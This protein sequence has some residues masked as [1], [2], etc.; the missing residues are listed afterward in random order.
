[1]KINDVSL[2]AKNYDLLKKSLDV[3]VERGRVIANNI[4]N[5]NT[6][7]YKRY[8]VT[9]EDSLKESQEELA[10]EVTD[11]KHIKNSVEYGKSEIK[12]DES[13]SMRKDGNNVDVD[14]EMTNLA[15]NTLKYNALI[16][17]LNSRISMKRYIISGGK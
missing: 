6:K 17:E 1:M 2:S 9:F 10:L 4:A 14:N 7:G 12:K 16:T 15:A 13:T 8:Y 5:F 11:E 3:S